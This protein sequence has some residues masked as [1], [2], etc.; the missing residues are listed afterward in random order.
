M[1]AASLLWGQVFQEMPE[2]R[3]LISWEPSVPPHYYL[4]GGWGVGAEYE[5]A[6]TFWVLT[7]EE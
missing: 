2:P 7:L 4:R 6:D 3:S 1:T 5:Y